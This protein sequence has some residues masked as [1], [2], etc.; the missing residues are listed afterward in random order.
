M[1]GDRLGGL[2]LVEAVAE[3]LVGDARGAGFQLEEEVQQSEVDAC[4]AAEERCARHV[5]SGH[6]EGA[7]AHAAVGEGGGGDE[8]GGTGG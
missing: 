4:A 5:V 2:P 3:G 6:G 8:G 1:P 7:L